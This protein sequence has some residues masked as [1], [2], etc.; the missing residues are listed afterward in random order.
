MSEQII[1]FYLNHVQTDNYIIS[2]KYLKCL[3][4]VLVLGISLVFS[5]APQIPG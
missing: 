2:A 4:N 5:L 1:L 3:A